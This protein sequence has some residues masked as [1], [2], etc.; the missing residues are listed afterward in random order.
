MLVPRNGSGSWVAK[1]DWWLHFG[2]LGTSQD[3][4][5][6]FIMI[7]SCRVREG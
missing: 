2:W 3:A 5:I 7:C 6:K 4:V 1:V